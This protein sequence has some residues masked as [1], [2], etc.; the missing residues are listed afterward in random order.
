MVVGGDSGS[1]GCSRGSAVAS[2]LRLS[3]ALEEC[4][5]ACDGL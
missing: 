1:W 2:S 3:N 5:S 4:V